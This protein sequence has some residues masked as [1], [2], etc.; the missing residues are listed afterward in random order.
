MSLDGSLRAALARGIEPLSGAAVTPGAVVAVVDGDRIV[1]TVAAG[2]TAGASDGG[3]P[4]HEGTVYDL[5]SLTKPLA[6]WA[7]AV[8]AIAA[9]QLAADTRAREILGE[10]APPAWDAIELRHL[11]GHSAGLPAHRDYYRELRALPAAEARRCL[12]DRALAE[13]LVDLPGRAALYSDLG[14]I[15]AA[16]ML[17][18]VDGRRLDAQF[19]AEIAG[20]L[21]MAATGFRPIGESPPAD[22]ATVA[23]TERDETRGLV[24]GEVHDENAHA[25]GGVCGHA[26]LFG[27]AGDVARFAIAVM[28]AARGEQGVFD[29]RVVAPLIATPSAPGTSWRLGWDTPSPPP[30]RSHA[31]DLWPRAGIGHL[32][33]TGTSLWLDPPNGRA[34]ALLTN[35]V[36]ASREPAAIRELRRAV[37]D[38][39]VREL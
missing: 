12:V 17:E 31:G 30:A 6:T 8:R 19:A 16:A 3:G 25:A 39:A 23:P 35:R 34:V 29:P 21:G 11:L 36:Y 38:A 26:G 15:A 4:V 9:G 33:F 24:N 5:A 2:E 13:P 37:M 1:A 32:G 27:T 22:A 28:A 20:P 14:Y 10:R 7:L 18:A